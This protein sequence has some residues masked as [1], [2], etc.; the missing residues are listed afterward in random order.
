MSAITGSFKIS[1]Q[2][3][4]I[5]SGSTLT[6]S[7]NEYNRVIFIGT[8][9]VSVYMPPVFSVPNGYEYVIINNSPSLVDVALYPAN[10]TTDKFYSTTITTNT[11]I[12]QGSSLRL[13]AW[14]NNGTQ[15]YWMTG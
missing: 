5:F 15:G 3:P 11:S 1:Q 14:H 8:S 13:L 6:L 12:S 9:F 2:Y 10:N 4:I 7:A